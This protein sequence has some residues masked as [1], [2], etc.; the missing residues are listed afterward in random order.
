M[1]LFCHGVLGG[2][3]YLEDNMKV[4]AFKSNE[5]VIVEMSAG[6]LLNLAGFRYDDDFNKAIVKCFYT[7]DVLYDDAKSDLLDVEIP[8]GELFR[9]AKETLAAYSEL[10]TKLESIRNQ[11]TTLTKKMEQAQGEEE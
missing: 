5:V 11:I 6:E 8:V 4:I 7:S 10:K 9:E 3:F 1:Y 2:V